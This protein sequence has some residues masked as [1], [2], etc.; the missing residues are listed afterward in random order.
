MK[1]ITLLFVFGVALAGLR[2]LVA[3]PP[4]L[5]AS[6]AE[7]GESTGSPEM[8]IMTNK[9]DYPLHAF[10]TGFLQEGDSD[11]KPGRSLFSF[12]GREPAWYTVN[13]DVMGG[14]SNSV[15]R[16]NT[17]LQRL[18]F[19]GKVSLENDGGFAT[20]RSEWTAYDLSAFD[21]IAL[22]VRGDGNVYRFRIHADKTVLGIAYT[23]WFR[24]EAGVWQE[25]YI[26]F[27][28]M[29]P[30]YRGFVVHAAGPLAPSSIRSFGLMLSDKQ[31]GEFALEI[32]WI[33]AVAE[34]KNEFQY[35]N[36]E[37]S[38]EPRTSKRQANSG[39]LQAS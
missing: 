11:R 17:E 36:S 23:A 19:S 22:R 2:F 29:V 34:Q 38:L 1:T 31:E 5:E 39:A 14:V 24:T 32:D 8:N 15:V 7:T 26:P 3:H 33:R 37:T 16:V 21:G 27:A 9:D 35:A 6:G 4:L 18:S 10:H 30:L 12:N 20:A 13:D 25:L 28:E